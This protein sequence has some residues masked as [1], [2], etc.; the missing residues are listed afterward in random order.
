MAGLHKIAF[1]F[2]EIRLSLTAG[3]ASPNASPT[4]VDM[5]DCREMSSTQDDQEN[6]QPHDTP[7]TEPTGKLT[8]SQKKKLRKKQ[9][10]QQKKIEQ[11]NE[12]P[13]KDET[14]D[15]QTESKDHV[16]EVEYVA[17]VDQDLQ[18]DPLFSQF[19]KIFE[20]FRSGDTRRLDDQVSEEPMN[21]WKKLV[22]RKKPVELDLKGDDNDDENINGDAA[23]K[24][25]KRKLKLMT[26]M[27][28]AE[29]KT[30]VS[31]P[32]LVEM[33]DVTAKDPFTL[34][35]LKSTRN[36]V[37]VPRHWCFKR[38]YLQGKRGFEKPPFKLP[39][40]IRR[41][42][43]MEMREAILE[44]DDAKSLK[45][46]MR[47]KMRPKMGKIDIDYQKLHD[48]F[49]K[50]QTKPP[51]TGHG[52][53]Y[54]EGKEFETVHKDKKPGELSNELRT[55][56]GMP[57]GG[58]SAKIP[59]PWLIAMQ[60]YGPPP[61]YPNQKIPG[62]NA[63]IPEG[64]SFGYQAGGWGK[65]PVDEY[66]RPLYGDVFGLTGGT[67][68]AIK[69]PDEVID[70]TLWGEMDEESEE[71][72]SEEEEED[73]EKEDDDANEETVTGDAKLDGLVTPS[74]GLTTPGGY[75]SSIPPGIETPGLIELRKRKIEEEMEMRDNPALYQVLSEKKTDRLTS[76]MMASTHIYDVSASTS[77]SKRK[78]LGP[79]G[80]VYDVA[81]DPS[82]LELD[83]EQI[84]SRLQEKIQSADSM[85]RSQLTK[86]P[87]L[88]DMLSRH[89]QETASKKKNK[90]TDDSK[91]KK[92][93]DFKF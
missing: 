91:K 64:C 82:E 30:K 39:E 8:K 37:P 23:E 51:M 55:A 28:V 60:R 29:L 63:P 35:L 41:T 59:P 26:R 87:E 80:Q 88:S 70:K 57:I 5:D 76:S 45:T 43:I 62:L 3:V 68:N 84:H 36:T 11:E 81:L 58:N 18:S 53:L 15:N 12:E 24:L 49:F 44:K 66:G 71:D 17:E 92:Y 4:R 54:F 31:H 16:V 22:E 52:D 10:R 21:D 93:K 13:L 42:G 27:S 47:E 89:I 86:D 33:H 56:L 50:W 90:P 61:S 19:S 6:E 14:A 9:K 83:P 2:W 65:P 72:E 40:F 7:T 77:G 46:K 79:D 74:E 75:A 34:H 78:K 1:L 48:A 38:K 25:S 67:K 20:K 85:S 32:E 69:D 73:E